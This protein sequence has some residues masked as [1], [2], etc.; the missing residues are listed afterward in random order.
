M[1]DNITTTYHG[2]RLS[3]HQLFADRNFRLVIPIIQREYA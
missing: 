1:A 2:E 3:F